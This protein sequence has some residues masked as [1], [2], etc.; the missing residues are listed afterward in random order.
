MNEKFTTCSI[1]TRFPSFIIH[2]SLQLF[3]FTLAFFAKNLVASELGSAHFYVVALFTNLL[4]RD[5]VFS[6]NCALRK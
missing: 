4:K 5:L 6:L 3:N 2:G 1:I